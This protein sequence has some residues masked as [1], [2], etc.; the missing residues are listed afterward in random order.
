[1]SLV[2]FGTP[3]RNQLTIDVEPGTMRGRPCSVGGDAGVEATVVHHGP[4]DVDVADDLPVQCYVLAHH[5]PG[6]WDGEYV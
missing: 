5:V 3:C 2:Y 6:A 4:A 1:M